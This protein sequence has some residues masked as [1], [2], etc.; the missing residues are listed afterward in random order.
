MTEVLPSLISLAV[1]K[2]GTPAGGLALARQVNVVLSVV[3]RG[4]KVR[5]LVKD[6]VEP[7]TTEIV[8][9]ASLLDKRVLPL[10]Q[11][12][13]VSVIAISVSVAGLMEMLQVSVRGVMLPA[14]SGPGGTM[15][16]TL[17][18]ETAWKT[19][20]VANIIRVSTD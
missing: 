7:D 17:G 4:S 14:N 15:M 8:T 5:V 9:L 18:V 3:L 20:L 10:S 16:I 12:I 13:S 6:G 2:L 1:M 19:V 11:V